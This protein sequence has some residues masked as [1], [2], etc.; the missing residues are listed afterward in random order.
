MM[1]RMMTEFPRVCSVFDAQSFVRTL[2]ALKG[3]GAMSTLV[4]GFI[5]KCCCKQENSLFH[6]CIDLI[7]T[8]RQAFT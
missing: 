6:K 3:G 2:Q 5:S 8:V 1:A 4:Q 7:T